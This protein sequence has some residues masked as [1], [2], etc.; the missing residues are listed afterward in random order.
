VV[1]ADRTLAVGDRLTTGAGEQRVVL[2]PDGSRLFVREQTSFAVK[3]ASA[4]HLTRG[5]V[6]VE[7]AFGKLA[8]T[9]H[10]TT[11]KRE[12]R[13]QESRF[14]VRAS[15]KGTHVVVASGQVRIEGIEQSVRAG[16]QL[17]EKAVK[18][19]SAPR[20]T[21]LARWTREL[22][23]AAPLVPVSEHVGGTL[24]VHDPSGQERQLELRR[25]HIDVHIEDGFARTTIDQTFFNSS[26]ERLEGTFRFPLPADASLSRLAMYVDGKRMEGGMT[27]R[28]HARAVYEQIVYARKDPALL[29]WVDGS[30]FK[31]RV[32]PLEG[33]Q[34]KRLLLSYTQKLPVLYG[35][36]SYRFPSGHSL[37]QVKEWS[38]HARVKNGAGRDWVCESHALKARQVGGDLLLDGSMKNARLDRQ[39]TIQV[40]DQ[41]RSEVLFSKMEHE[42][43]K[44]LLVR[45]RPDL[46]SIGAYQRRDWVVL[47]ES[48]GDRDPLLMR[49]QIELVRG[50]LSNANRD[51]TFTILTANTRTKATEP[52]SNEFDAIDEAMRELEKVHLVGALD[53]GAALSAAKP[54][55]EASKNPY[56]VHV[57]SGIA[58]M[59][60]SQTTPLIS[61]LP[62]ETRY[63]GIGI[64]RRW[65]RSFMQAAAEKT[66]GYY[67]QVNPD[68]I[69]PWRGLEIVATLNAPRLLDVQVSD[70]SGKARFLPI[71]RLVC[72]GEEI[73]AITRVTDA[74]PSRVRITGKLDGKEV[75]NEVDV[76]EVRDG[77]GC[78]PR[79]WAKLEIE[80][81]LLEDPARHKEAIVALSKAMY[82]MTPFTSL[83]VLET[84]DMYTQFKV[85]RGRKDHWA[86]YPAPATIKVVHEPLA[87]SASDARK[88]GKPSAEAV[89]KT[90]VGEQINP[91]RIE[92]FP[93]FGYDT[94]T[95]GGLFTTSAFRMYTQTRWVAREEALRRL[96]AMVKARASVS[97]AVSRSDFDAALRQAIWAVQ[98]VRREGMALRGLNEAE[99]VGNNLAFYPLTL[100]ALV[101]RG[102]SRQDAL[103]YE[104]VRQGSSRPKDWNIHP[105]LLKQMRSPRMLPDAPHLDLTPTA[106]SIDL[107]ELGYSPD[108]I[109]HILVDL[110][111]SST[112]KDRA[113]TLPLGG[114]YSRPRYNND[115]RLFSNLLRYAPGLHSSEADFRGVIEA[116]ARP[117]ASAKVGQIDPQA[118]K[119]FEAARP[120]TWR[121]F[122]IEEHRKELN[123]SIV[124]DSA[125]RWTWQRV[126]PSGLKEQV[127]C[128]GKTLWHLYP[129]L[130]LAGKREVSRFHRL[131]LS[132]LVPGALPRP[133]DY[134][135][136]ADVVLL[137][138]RLVGV[139]PHAPREKGTSVAHVQLHLVFDDRGQLSERQWVLMPTRILL[140]KERCQPG[141]EAR[142]PVLVPDV[143]QLVVLSLPYRSTEHLHDQLRT[144]KKAANEMTIAEAIPL[145]ASY[146]AQNDAETARRI[147]REALHAREQRQLGLYVLLAAVDVALDNEVFDV[148]DQHPGDALA[149]Y[150]AIHSSPTL[151]K[152]A[153]RWAAAS[154][155]WGDGF[156]GRLGVGHD[157]LLRWSSQHTIGSSPKH[158]AG[159]RRRALE[160]VRRY[161]GSDLAWGI[162]GLIQERLAEEK[163][164]TDTRRAWAELATANMLFA[165]HPRLRVFAR[166][167]AA[168]C[169]WKAGQSAEARKRFVALH[170]DTFK[171][172]G[173]LSLDADFRA[174]LM[175]TD[176]DNWNDR[177]Q[178]SARTLIERKERHAVLHLAKQAWQLDDLP[179]ALSLCRQMMTDA[180]PRGKEGLVLYTAS[181]DFLMKTGQAETAEPLLRALLAEPEHAKRP[182]LWRLAAQLAEQREQSA[183]ILEYTEKALA[184]EY[185]QPSEVIN[186]EQ[187]RKEYA[188]LLTQ[189]ESLA[190]ALKTLKIPVPVGFRDK[191][192]LVADRWRALDRNQES[193]CKQCAAVLR[194]L[195]EKELA[196]DYLTTPVALRPG[197]A[198][199]WTSLADSL[200]KQGELDLADRAYQSAFER[201]STNAQ[202]LWDRAENLRQAGRQA[203]A[204]KLYQQLAESNWQPRFVSLRT[205]A[206]WILEGK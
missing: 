143:K 163:E 82:V 113:R 96:R 185:E 61:K 135:R 198:D 178:R 89:R 181:I 79:T 190:R 152:H 10:I 87:G 46:P 133:E 138:N 29:E 25:Y 156:L 14:G 39:V 145:L 75:S 201:E 149:G 187:V 114:T 199:T 166:Y 1:R 141:E 124:H 98:G 173:L 115:H 40:Q 159:E 126:L 193:A 8:P 99:A 202:I 16:Q 183:Q 30:T 120:S 57:G 43:A 142:E 179:I 154:N 103:A 146:V 105:A 136:G 172:G 36:V 170:E 52:V 68:E 85:D 20:I 131:A 41:A 132:S 84:E 51:D 80:R 60:E 58:A 12:L 35:S 205:Q 47:V 164:D 100:G 31:M 102:T 26:E 157:L 62:K 204:R 83:L 86:M 191:V 33:R 49:T 128:D 73:A 97:G 19:S 188:S 3:G 11:S 148:V 91:V 134:A 21:H 22:R 65:N 177:M 197:E 112:E 182:D 151:R 125:D 34:E 66:G 4:L 42:G 155:A 48:S 189:Y 127:V 161:A 107:N 147:F 165:D 55:L 7:T 203:Q 122:K 27:D 200:K 45:Y 180:S 93:P 88:G 72:Q 108:R 5:E 175:G 196:W 139:I 67:T 69:I 64:G 38:M 59:G 123:Y 130:G 106:G 71:E 171:A 153:S 118:R 74:L 95:D 117:D 169:L 116:E 63:V 167:E 110:P 109:E 104:I 76:G 129:E 144:R 24:V 206:R 194:I 50:I 174:A 13:A 140:R 90:V 32:F 23:Q 78:L 2:L 6:F 44:Y 162:L 158:R 81:L 54:V 77:A 94:P 56:L 160:Y 70:P 192:I 28:D 9:L 92:G 53:L 111:V 18:P 176:K 150:L 195:G 184:L 119:L 101:I 15:E 121:I 17:E 137:A 186:L 37:T 168:R